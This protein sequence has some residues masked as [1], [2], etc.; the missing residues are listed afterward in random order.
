MTVD[1]NMTVDNPQVPQIGT[2]TM[3]RTSR[4]MKDETFIEMAMEL[5]R[6][7]GPI[8]QM[9]GTDPRT[10]LVSNFALADEICDDQR[11]DKSL[12]KGLR[13]LRGLVGDALFTAYTSEPNWHKAH[14]IL[15]PTFSLQAMK[16][17][18]PDMLDL[19]GQLALKWQRQNPKD[20][21]DV[22]QDMTRLTIDT[23]GLCGFNHRFNSFYRSDQH[24]F[25]VA[26]VNTLTKTTASYGS[27]HPLVEALT[28]WLRP[29][30]AEEDVFSTDEELRHDREVMNAT[31]DKVIKARKAEGPEAMA[32]HH[33]L[34]SYMLTGRDRQTGEGLNDV[35]I[36]YEIITFLIA[37]HETTSG[38]LSFAL[39]F[40]LKHPDV[41]AKAYAEVDDVLGM[42]LRVQPTY[43]QVHRLRYVSQIL[44]ESLRLWPP[45]PAF[46]RCP[47]QETTLGGK[48]VVRPDDKI[49]VLSAMLQR[50]P[51]VW[52]ADAEEF[53]PDHFRPEAEQTRPANA[54]KAFGTGQ[55]GCIGREFALQ[56]AALVL[57]MVLQRFELIDFSNYELRLK[58]TLTIK[59]D[60]FKIRVRPRAS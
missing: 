13:Q 41:L 42:D 2:M 59:P 17:Y 7:H 19:A 9:P 3:V 24:P 43:E 26:M 29:S 6:Q 18:M 33:D 16:G 21:I 57:G 58:Q 27:G 60:N 14:N 38:L 32:A 35:T 5:M 40:L 30:P 49:M 44:K 53:N 52:G 25:V 31:V 28:R 54:F 12:G 45:A 23:I 56:E 10:F 4:A 22:P 55:R 34:L 1:K 39:Y 37:G 50:D 8:V 51:A 36:R 46:T 15:L 11:F 48:Y 47:L 20:E